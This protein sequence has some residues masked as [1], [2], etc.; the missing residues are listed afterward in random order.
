MPAPIHRTR[1]NTPTSQT[2]TTTL[3]DSPGTTRRDQQR[4]R[5]LGRLPPRP[6][7]PH[8]RQAPQVAGRRLGEPLRQLDH[9]PFRHHHA[10]AAI[11][12][13]Q[14]Q[15]STPRDARRP[16]RDAARRHTSHPAPAGPRFSPRSSSRITGLPSAHPR[17]A[18]QFLELSLVQL[19]VRESSS[20]TTASSVEP[21]KNVRTRCRTATRVRPHGPPLVRRC[22]AGH[23]RHGGCGL[24]LAIRSRARTA[25]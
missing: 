7:N 22:T 8:L 1:A 17:C 18:C 16:R 24:C 15:L 6:L 13:P 11:T 9:R 2:P 4:G 5:P 23:P 25:E 12:S 19:P 10:R 20:A 3:T 21:S 14:T